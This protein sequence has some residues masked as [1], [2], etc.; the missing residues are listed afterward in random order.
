MSLQSTYYYPQF[1]VERTQDQSEL[2]PTPLLSRGAVLAPASL[3]S[4]QS[5]S[6]YSWPYGEGKGTDL[7]LLSNPPNSLHPV[8]RTRGSCPLGRRARGRGLSRLITN[9]LP[10]R[11][12]RASLPSWRWRDTYWLGAG[13]GP[14]VPAAG[15][16]VAVRPPDCGTGSA[17]QFLS[18][19]SRCCCFISVLGA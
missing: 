8:P 12:P 15:M 17:T 9:P 19:S 11:A 2:G 6:Y 5:A 3:P 1:T 18:L 13:K 16:G 4:T 14:V 10:L 7:S